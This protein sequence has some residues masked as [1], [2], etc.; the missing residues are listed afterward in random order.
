MSEDSNKSH[1]NYNFFIH[2]TKKQAIKNKIEINKVNIKMNSLQ[3]PF[4]EEV[5]GFPAII[6]SFSLLGCK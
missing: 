4:P 3:K 1:V 5:T 2:L 6:L